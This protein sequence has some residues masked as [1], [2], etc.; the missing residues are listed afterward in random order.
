MA[1]GYSKLETETIITYNDAEDEAGVYTGNRAL[2]NKLRSLAEQYP[3][4][5]KLERISHGGDFADYIVPKKW[6]KVSPPRKVNLSDEQ[7]AQI[8]ARLKSSRKSIDVQ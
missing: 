7:R 1:E 3:D 5:C 6:I 4:E 8:A 2:L